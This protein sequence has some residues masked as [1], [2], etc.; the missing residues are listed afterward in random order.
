M[1]FFVKKLYKNRY[2]PESSA[3]RASDVLPP[4]VTLKRAGAFYYYRKTTKSNRFC[5][6]PTFA[7]IFHFT[8][9][10]C[11]TWWDWDAQIFLLQG[12]GYPNTPLRNRE[13]RDVQNVNK[14]F[15]AHIQ[16]QYR[17]SFCP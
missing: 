5:F 8:T 6:F 1:I 4:S 16:K 10:H 9:L 7:P 17:N 2:I 15:V 11:F 3:P 13:Y 14:I 12:T